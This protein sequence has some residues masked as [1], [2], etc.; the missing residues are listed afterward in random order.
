MPLKP[1]AFIRDFGRIG[2]LVFG[3]A[4]G[5]PV[6]AFPAP[7]FR[8][9]LQGHVAGRLE[10]PSCQPPTTECDIPAAEVRYQQTVEGYLADQWSYTGKADL[11]QDVALDETRARVR[12]LYLD[13]SGPSFTARGGRQIITW[14]VGDLLFI[15][16]TFPKDWNAFFLG[17]PL[18]YLKKPSDAIRFD[19]YPTGASFELIVAHFEEDKQ[20]DPRRFILPMAPDFQHLEEPN[21]GLEDLEVSLKGSTYLQSWEL[22]GY[23][24][25]THFRTPGFRVT[26]AGVA[27]H[28]PRLN[29]YGL[30]VTGPLSSGVVSFEAGYYDSVDDRDG[31]KPGVA[32]SQTRVLLGYSRQLWDEATVGV[33]L[34]SERM[35]Q[36]ESYRANLQGTNLRDKSREIAT[37]RLTQLMN[38]QTLTLNLFTFVGL[39][40][41]DHYLIPSIRYNAT[42]RLWGEIGMNLFGGDRDGQFGTFKDNSNLYFT[43]RYTL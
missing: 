25:K 16:D 7:D 21:D 15:N 3:L 38:Y 23:A 17:Q 9:F 28:Y 10:N 6:Q 43:L 39:S 20:P 8:G 2:F 33:Q 4:V 26:E 27:G 22:S 32:N 31:D 30:S 19:W 34:Y 40:E 36:Y 41:Q 5:D 13:Y 1:P 14:G 11:V 12:E 35:H 42:D 29:T 37:I 24:S 18:H